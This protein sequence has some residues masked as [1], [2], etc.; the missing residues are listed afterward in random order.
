MRADFLDAVLLLGD[1]VLPALGRQLGDA[2][3]PARVELVAHVLLEE[4]VARHAVAF[5]QP[6]QAAFVRD[7]ALVDV[8]ELLDQRIDARLVEPQ[9][10]H[11]GDDLF[12]QLLVLALLRR[13]Q[14]GALQAELDVLLLQAAQLLEVVGDVVEG[15]DHL[16]LELGLDGGERQRILHVVFV[17]IALGRGLGR[18]LLLAVGGGLARRL[19]RRR[20]GRRGRRRR[21]LHDLQMRRAG[22]RRRAGHGG[23]RDRL[24]VG[25]DDHRHL[26][27]LGVGAGVG[28]FEIDDVAQEDLAVVQFVA[29]DDD[30]LEGQRA[31]AQAGDHRLAAG[32]D[33]LG[34]GDF[35]LA[36]QQFDRAH[37][38]QIHAH[39]IVGALGRLFLFGGGERLRLRLDDL[40]AGVVV[41][42]VAARRSP[43]PRP[44]RCRRP[45]SP[46]R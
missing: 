24:A 41:I 8:V 43:S 29:P 25:A 21:R 40:G 1:Q 4:L 5:R 3:E 28:R 26:H 32:F 44:L 23:L 39:R 7:E 13:R 22:N 27:L 42:V 2:V 15:L 9:R 11:L 38:A 20:G 45:R 12:L 19:E 16:R 10:L 33:A 18:I 31:F 17:V 30:G 36:R 34:D 37:F 35:A 46:P 6:H 14:R